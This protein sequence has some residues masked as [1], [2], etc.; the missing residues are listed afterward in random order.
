[1][2]TRERIPDTGSP[3]GAAQGIGRLRRGQDSVTEPVTAGVVKSLTP[4]C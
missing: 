4:P 3:N 1:M 2:K